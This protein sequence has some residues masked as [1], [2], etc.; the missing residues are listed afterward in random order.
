M[1]LCTTSTAEIDEVPGE[2]RVTTVPSERRN[3]RRDRAPWIPARSDLEREKKE[4]GTCRILKALRT[5]SVIRWW[6]RDNC[7]DIALMLSYTETV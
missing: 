5:H 6:G 1:S 7:D 4:K 3:S 2:E